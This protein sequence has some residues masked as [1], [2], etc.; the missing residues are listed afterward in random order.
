MDLLKNK[1]EKNIKIFNAQV[2]PF[3]FKKEEIIKTKGLYERVINWVSGE[4]DLYL[5]N[6]SEILKV[7]FPNGWFT[8]RNIKD[9]NSNEFIEIIVEGKSRIACQNMM[10]QLESIYSYIVSF[11]EAR[12]LQYT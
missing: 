1:L 9:E 6:E 2:P 4:F 8:I 3:H 7:Y 5:K 10:N 11:S 12:E